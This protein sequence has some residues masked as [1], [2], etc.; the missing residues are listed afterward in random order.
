MIKMIEVNDEVCYGCGGEYAPG[1]TIG[2]IHFCNKC[3][4]EHVT[5][6]LTPTVEEATEPETSE[7]PVKF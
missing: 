6:A 7:E 4:A 1:V 5:I 3:I 2:D